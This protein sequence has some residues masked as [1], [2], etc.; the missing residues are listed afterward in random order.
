MRLRALLLSCTLA[1]APIAGQAQETLADI[2][3]DMSI[4]FVE[5]QRLK[6]ELSTTG[7][8]AVALPPGALDRI[9]AIES[10]LQRLTSKTEELEFRVS[11]V[12]EDGARRLGD[13]EFRVCELEEGCDIG[14]IGQV[15]TLGGEVGAQTSPTPQPAPSS[16]GTELAV[17]EETDFRRAEE[18][19]AQGDFQS[20]ADQFAAFRE[21]YPGGP[22]EAKALVREGR[23]LEGLGNTR[24]AARRYLDAYA[25]Y[26]DDSAGPEA[27]WRL[28]AA[29]GD[30]GN[31]A[32]ACVTLDEVAGRYPGSS[33][34]IAEAAAA[35]TRFGCQ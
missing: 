22:L 12:A 21:T 32:E 17:G 24:D 26:P 25:G 33:E 11:R 8:S 10:E 30:L 35:K 34:A 5:L 14:A 6:R 27:L 2:R 9:N 13:L 15:P 31:L 28:G 7:A 4:L 20:A 23:A 19:L 18:A 29:L 16:V 3:Q 1:L